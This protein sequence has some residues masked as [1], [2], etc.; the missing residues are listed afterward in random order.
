MTFDELERAIAAALRSDLGR[1]RR[2]VADYARRAAR[3]GDPGREARARFERAQLEHV[4]GRHR[5]AAADYAGARTAFVRLRNRAF[6][7]ASDIGAVQ[8]HALLGDR[9]AMRRSIGRLRRAAKPGLETA[10]AELAIGSAHDSLGDESAAESS[11]QNALATLR[12]R[13]E[14]DRVALVRATARHN[15]ALRL[16]RRGAVSRALRELDSALDFYRSR[17][18]EMPAAIAAAN[19][20]W[21]LGVAGHAAD[22]LQQ[23][24]AA[25][26]AFVDLKDRRRGALALADEAELLLRLGHA[27][28][29]RDRATAAARILDRHDAPLEAARTRLLSARA[30]QAAGRSAKAMA[31]RAAAAFAAAGDRA[32]AA[33]AAAIAGED[34]ARA[35]A[36]LLRTGHWMAALDALLARARAMAPRTGARLLKRRAPRYPAP[37]RRWISPDLLRLCAAGADHPIPL[38]RRAFRAAEELRGRAPSGTLRSAVLTAH[39]EIYADLAR[40]LLARDRAADRREAFLVIDAA[41]ART[42]REEAEREAPGITDRPRARAARERLEALWRTLERRD[43]EP[44]GLRG[45]SR[46]LFAEVTRCEHDLMDALEERSGSVGPVAALPRGPC[47]AFAILSGEVV[48]LLARGGEVESWS[49]GRVQPLLDDLAA[50]RFQVTRRLHGATDARPALRALERIAD[51]VFAHAPSLP[52]RFCV[53]L[54]PE[55]GGLPLEALPRDG[56]PLLRHATISYA[57]CAAH[58][59]P[60]RVAA[61]P[62]L[63]VG[64]D[65]HR[66]PAIREELATVRRLTGAVALEGPAATRGALLDALPGKR[67]VHIAGH[68]APREDLALLSS[69]QLRDGWITASD[70]K[71]VR[72]SK[73]LVVLSGCRTGDPSLRWQGE[74]LGGFP[75]VLLAAG[76]AGLCA[77]RWEVRD[78]V[79]AE[80]MDAFY[81]ELSHRFP[82]EAVAAAACRMLSSSNH[83]CDWAAFLFIRGVNG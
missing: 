35:E 20:G 83:P 78:R 7:V 62:A 57:A 38:L 29:A 28:A 54:P 74:A 41:R 50:F 79:A 42:L 77:S 4:A 9:E 23:L 59:P 44:G 53:V 26:A 17:K 12:G 21:I 11:I 68:A 71:G 81:E 66:L 76:V 2:L 30:Q 8:V 27:T 49:C 80:W 72:L 32:G 6:A 70:L 82:D 52:G 25:Q 16:A 64:L 73:A 39:L 5:R 46:T 75:R 31:H 3:E 61:G 19:R 22:A 36:T 60:R 13:R 58:S 14:T 56:Q 34:L 15:L 51:R 40:A 45:A 24:Q 18:M 65:D 43:S 63:A 67:L 47:L 69:L 10:G 1:A 33:M 55:L 48:G 37:L